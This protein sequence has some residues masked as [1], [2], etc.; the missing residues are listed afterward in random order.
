MVKCIRNEKA[1]IRHLQRQRDYTL[2]KLYLYTMKE[3]FETAVINYIEE[4]KRTIKK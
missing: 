1:E 4:I 3:V 2:F